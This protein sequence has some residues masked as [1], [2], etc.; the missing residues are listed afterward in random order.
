[1]QDDGHP[2]ITFGILGPLTVTVDGLPV[3]LGAAKT[4][5]LLAS[6]LLRRA[7]VIAV[8]EL[9]DRLWDDEPPAGARN[10]VHTYVR[11]LRGALRTA[12]RL[13]VTEP[14]GYLI[15]VPASAIDVNRF[16]EHVARARAAGKAGDTAAE[17]RELRAGLALWR[18]APLADIRSDALHRNEVSRLVEERLH[19]IERRVELDLAAGRAAEL[20]AELL[21][22]TAEHPLRERLWHQLMLALYR[23][24]RQ[25]D[26]LATFRNVRAVRRR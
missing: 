10:A 20:V 13:I 4:R 22:L 14:A 16:R 19:A 2:E 23:S 7:T 21:S 3:A 12:G 25:A 18:G 11:R 26:A 5:I 1:M 15:D 17:G 6:L 8:D 9:V 24:H